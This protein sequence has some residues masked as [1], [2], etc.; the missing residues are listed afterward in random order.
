MPDDTDDRFRQHEEMLQ[1]VPRILAAQH[2]IERLDRS[3][4]G[5]HRTLAYVEMT[6]A[7]MKTL[8][9]RVFRSQ[10]NGRDA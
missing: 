2:T 8:C 6:Q 4:E 3:L 1:D 9:T 10:E 5:I 7:R